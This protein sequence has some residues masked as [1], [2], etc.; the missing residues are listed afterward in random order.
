MGTPLRSKVA[1]LHEQGNFRKYSLM[2]RMDSSPDPSLLLA[3]NRANGS[4]RGSGLV[5]VLFLLIA[6]LL[7]AFAVQRDDGETAMDAGSRM[8]HAGDLSGAA[9]AFFDASQARI[10]S[11]ETLKTGRAVPSPANP[12]PPENTPSF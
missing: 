8:F 6:A 5:R 9:S 2:E 4:V 7:P 3:A 1:A 11:A 12:L 10:P